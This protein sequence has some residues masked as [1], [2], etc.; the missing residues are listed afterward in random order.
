M[1][2][3]IS[4]QLVSYLDGELAPPLREEV[5]QH[6]ARC[7]QC[8]R[9]LKEVEAVRG[10]LARWPEPEP[11]A[12]ARGRAWQELQAARVAPARQTAAWVWPAS[13][14]IRPLIRYALAVAA[15][16]VVAVLVTI[17]WERRADMGVPEEMLAE[18]PVL[19]DMDMLQVYDVLTEWENLE[20]L[21]ALEGAPVN[22]EGTTQ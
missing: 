16:V 6:I 22:E 17:S 12:E 1:A 20:A 9:E 8:A 2:C 21:T 4:E 7:P 18:L 19:E 5:V 11:G 10:L 3:K 15:V 14:A 13:P